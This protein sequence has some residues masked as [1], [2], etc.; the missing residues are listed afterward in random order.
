MD[1]MVG[2]CGRLCCSH[3]LGLGMQACAPPPPPHAHNQGLRTVVA[4]VCLPPPSPGVG[5]WGFF[6]HS[7]AISP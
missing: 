2:V 1:C 4:F 5:G 3:E 7:G 6:C